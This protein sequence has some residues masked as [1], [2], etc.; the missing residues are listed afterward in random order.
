MAL[1]LVQWR[2]SE[3]SKGPLGGKGRTTIKAENFEAYLEEL[4]QLGANELMGTN[5]VVLHPRVRG[6]DVF[7]LP[8]ISGRIFINEQTAAL[9]EDAEFTGLVLKESRWLK[10]DQE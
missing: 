6:F 7:A 8:K 2:Q 5:K 4:K 1:D 3:F 9:L 10:L